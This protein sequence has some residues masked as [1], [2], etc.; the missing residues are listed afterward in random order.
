MRK[1]ELEALGD[2]LLDVGALD[3]GGLLNLRNL[4][5]LYYQKY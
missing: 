3:V 1:R 5:D 4:E 2:D